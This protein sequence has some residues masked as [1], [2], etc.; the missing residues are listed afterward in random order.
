MLLC[1]THVQYD[2]EA[3][4]NYHNLGFDQNTSSYTQ[5]QSGMT[6]IVLCLCQIWAEVSLHVTKCFQYFVYEHRS[7][8]QQSY[9]CDSPASVYSP[10]IVDSHMLSN[11]H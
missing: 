11:N 5:I 10:S 7:Q 1:Y 6:L 8:D 4:D 3:Q 2:Q 9:M